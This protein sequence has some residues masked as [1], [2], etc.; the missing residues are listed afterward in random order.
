MLK[1]H[2]SAELDQARLDRR[3]RRFGAD[4]Q[5]RRSPPHHRGIADRLGRCDQQ[6]PAG[7]LR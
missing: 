3:R 1:P 4:S 7:L 5:T 6:Q 2:P